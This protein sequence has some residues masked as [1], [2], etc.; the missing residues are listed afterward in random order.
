M[1][2]GDIGRDPIGGQCPKYC[3]FQ[4]ICRKERALGLEGEDSED[5]A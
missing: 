5:E 1:Q 4:P 3:H 2:A